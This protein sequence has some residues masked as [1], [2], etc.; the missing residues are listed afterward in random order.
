M[1]KSL[2]VAWNIFEPFFW[3]GS[4]VLCFYYYDY[5]YH[6][7]QMQK[8]NFDLPIVHPRVAE[9]KYKWM[10]TGSQGPK[11]IKHYHDKRQVQ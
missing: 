11:N 4:Y 2:M 5:Y 6:P 8:T 10:A 1:M 3:V 9:E 7:T